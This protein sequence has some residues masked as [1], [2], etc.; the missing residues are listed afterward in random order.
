VVQRR[1]AGLAAHQITVRYGCNT[2]S[3]LINPKLPMV[4]ELESGQTKLEEE[5][6]GRR[7]V[8]SAASFFQVN[9]RREQRLLPESLR[10]GT[11]RWL[12]DHP[13][14]SPPPS[15]GEG[16][17]FDGYFSMADLLAMLVLESMAPQPNDVVLDAYCGVGTFAALLAPKVK[18]VIGIEESNAAVADARVNCADLV[19]V[20]FLVGRTERVLP[21][22]KVGT[23][24]A[25]VLDPSR[26]GC[27]PPM[28]QGLLDLHPERIVYVSCDAATLARDLKALVAGG[29]SIEQVEPLDMFPQ[30]AHIETVTKLLSN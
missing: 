11:S 20:E 25:V 26:L 30:T 13:L 19:N 29:Y 2:G 9:T 10:S 24:Q 7:F 5:V 27:A 21:E 22:L 14:P 23:V 28:L 18:L 15:E 3:L 12:G 6:L 8:V 16:T 17:E 4:P 1:C